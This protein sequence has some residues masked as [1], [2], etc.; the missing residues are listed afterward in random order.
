[1]SGSNFPPLQ[2]IVSREK[3]FQLL[4]RAI[5][6]H[7][8]N[9]ITRII[10]WLKESLKRDPDLMKDLMN[11]PAA[12]NH[13]ICYLKEMKEFDELF[14][15]LTTLNRSEEAAFLEYQRKLEQ[16]KDGKVRA[17]ALRSTVEI[18]FR[19]Q[20]ELK[21]ESQ[22]IDEQIKLLETQ[23][24]LAEHDKGLKLE[25]VDKLKVGDTLSQTLWYLYINHWADKDKITA[26]EHL[27][28]KFNIS[29]LEHE[30][31]AITAL[32]KDRLFSNVKQ[33][34]IIVVPHS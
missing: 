18:H 10:I 19:S 4:D 30:W 32:A 28:S 7:D 15:L 13:Y 12:M 29:D 27:R 8:G 17:G 21:F 25:D 9:A 1:M 33:K 20:R 6:R 14:E 31:I 22:L 16:N 3:K 26:P 11:R 34:H 5:E 23:V 2:A 24:G